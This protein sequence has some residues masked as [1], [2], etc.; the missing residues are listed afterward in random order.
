MNIFHLVIFCY[1]VRNELK[2]CVLV[3]KRVYYSKFL[4]EIWNIY[5]AC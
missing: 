3:Q 4:D 2:L 5:I 1:D